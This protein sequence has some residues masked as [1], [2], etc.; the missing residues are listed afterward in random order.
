[1][2]LLHCTSGRWDSLSWSPG[3]RG[4]RSRGRTGS[5]V[6]QS[7]HQTYSHQLQWGPVRGRYLC[8]ESWAAH[9]HHKYIRLHSGVASD[10]SGIASD[11]FWNYYLFNNLVSD[12]TLLMSGTRYWRLLKIIIKSVIWS[13]TYNVV[14]LFCKYG[15]VVLL[16]CKYGGVVLLLCGPPPPWS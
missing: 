5:R 4:T 14:L 2:F 10:H 9:G 3:R 8:P 15:G 13:Q 7:S 1:M 11:R 12:L 6:L 16:L